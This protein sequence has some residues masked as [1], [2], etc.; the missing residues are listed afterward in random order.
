MSKAEYMTVWNAEHCID[1]IPQTDFEEAKQCALGILNDWAND[2][3]Q[4]MIQQDFSDDVREGWNEM[5]EECW[6]AVYKYNSDTKEYEEFWTPSDEDY[7]GIGVFGW[8]PVFTLKEMFGKEKLKD[9]SDAD[10]SKD[11]SGTI[12]KCKN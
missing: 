2:G 9:F 11:D 5:I 12:Y 7:E 1:S 6:V 8:F 3:Y 10:V 4:I